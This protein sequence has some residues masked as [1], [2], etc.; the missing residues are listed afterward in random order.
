MCEPTTLLIAA[1]AMQAA[2][3]IVGGINAQKSAN[4]RAAVADRNAN[5][6]RQAARDA[7][8]RG[9]IEEK[10]QNRRT[11]Q[12]L[13]AQRAAMAANGIEVD[14]GSAAD[15]QADTRMIGREDAQTI[16]ENAM[17]E[18]R[19]YDIRAWNANASASASRAEG[20]AALWGGIF[21]AGSS[22]LSAAYSFKKA[23][24]PKSA[25]PASFSS[26]GFSGYGGYGDS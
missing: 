4:F 22:I 10:R 9:D 6:E 2:G 26:Q 15:L 8:E 17:R 19:G 12:Q 7:L 20:K 11:A 16:R 3:S 24:A 5:L 18:T 25:S 14:F 21:D 13:G 1:T 23:Q